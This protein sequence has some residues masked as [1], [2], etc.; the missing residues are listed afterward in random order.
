MSITMQTEGQRIYIVGHTYPIRDR[1]RSAGAHW[2]G[3]RGAWWIGASKRADI[4]SVIASAAAATSRPDRGARV[5]GR[6]RYRERDYYCLAE[7][8][9]GRRLLRPGAEP[10]KV[11]HAGLTELILGEAGRGRTEVR[12]PIVGEGSS[13]RPKRTKEGKI[14]LVRGEFEDDGR[15]LVAVNAVGAYDRYRP[16]AIF[17]ARG[18][19][20]IAEGRRAFGDAG[21]INGG[22][23]ALAICEPGAAFILNDKY[24][25]WWY[26][27]NGTEWR[28]LTPEQRAAEEAAHQAAGDGGEWL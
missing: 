3:D 2:D 11:E 25:S 20:V 18:L 19:S 16:Y 6:A 15:C 5:I 10:A 22:P 28:R 9:D 17:A 4:E 27:W 23:E 14:V 26:T 13:V 21:R 7:S 12:I 24:R 1:L 8:R